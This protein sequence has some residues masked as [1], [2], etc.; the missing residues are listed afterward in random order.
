MIVARRLL[1]LMCF[2]LTLCDPTVATA[3]VGAP[4]KGGGRSALSLSPTSSLGSAIG[5]WQTTVL[6]ARAAPIATGA[7]PSVAA[8]AAA[9]SLTGHKL[10]GIASFYWQDQM[11]ANG[12]RFDKHA[13]TAAHKTLPFNT[14]VRVTHLASGRSVLVRINDRGPYKPGRVIDLSEAAAGML[15]MKGQGLAPVRI[16]VLR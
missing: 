5:R 10:E 15:G 9:G 16:D 6:F 13:M 11:T 3:E 12:E 1:V 2:S 7:I 14:R 4:T 8:P